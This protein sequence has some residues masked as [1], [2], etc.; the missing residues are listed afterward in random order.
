MLRDK[1]LVGHIR[2]REAGEQYM[3][4]S[5]TESSE[6]ACSKYEIIL[7]GGDAVFLADRQLGHKLYFGTERPLTRPELHRYI[8]TLDNDLRNLST[9]EFLKKYDLRG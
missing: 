7:I 4:L 2:V 1:Y 8:V 6:P 3:P 9:D 5:K